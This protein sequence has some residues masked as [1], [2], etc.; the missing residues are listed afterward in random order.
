MGVHLVDLLH[1]ALGVGE[2]GV[3]E[4]HGVP[5]IV[6]APVLPVLDDAVDGH[7]QLAVLGHHFQQ[8]C[9]ALVT[10][11]ALPEAI[12]PQGEHGHLPRQLPHLRHYAIGV[13]A[14]HEVVIHAVAHSGFECGA[15][16]VVGEAHGRIV[17]PIYAISFHGE[18]IGNTVLHV[19]RQQ[20]AVH[21]ALR[22]FAVLQVAQSIDG[23]ICF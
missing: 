1:H 4:F 9:L 15:L 2:V 11:A 5:Q 8:L 14:T 7:A 12:S 21:V 6:V 18:N 13:V 17:V 20:G 23:L 3:H 22:E 16:L 10:L 19:A